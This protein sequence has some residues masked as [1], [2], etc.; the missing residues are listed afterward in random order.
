MW[1]ALPSFLAEAAGSFAC[2]WPEKMPPVPN[3]SVRPVGVE[4]NRSSSCSSLPASKEEVSKVMDC[5][6][7]GSGCFF[8][9]LAHSSFCGPGK[10]NIFGI[11]F[12]PAGS[13]RV[14]PA[15]GW[16]ARCRRRGWP[17]PWAAGSAGCCSRKKESVSSSCCRRARSSSW[18]CCSRSS[19]SFRCCSSL[20]RSLAFLFQPFLLLAHRLAV[21]GQRGEEHARCCPSG[22]DGCCCLGCCCS[23][24]RGCLGGCCCCASG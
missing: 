4:A 22:L 2:C 18:R 19:A 13:G 10:K 15:V 12:Y 21:V 17:L 7:C 9:A 24:G 1:K 11:R 8:P 3:S 5:S 6:G 20:S 23:D 16:S 14:V